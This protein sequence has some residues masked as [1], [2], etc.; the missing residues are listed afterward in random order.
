MVAVVVLVAVVAGEVG[1]LGDCSGCGVELVL[2]VD[3]QFHWLDERHV[4]VL[5]KVQ[6]WL[7]W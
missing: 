6:Y 3:S 5:E 4:M 1:V 2:D 7:G